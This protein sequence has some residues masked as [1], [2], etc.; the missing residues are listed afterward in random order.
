MCMQNKYVYET[1]SEIEKKEYRSAT[2]R[3]F[4][5]LQAEIRNKKYN[6]N[7]SGR[8][9]FC[10]VLDLDTRHYVT[11]HFTLRDGDEAA[12]RRTLKYS[13]FFDI[14]NK[15]IFLAFIFNTSLYVTANPKKE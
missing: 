13:Y 14:S 7:S 6:S 1:V 11:A 9:R 10:S 4:F 8:S 15:M 12:S 3:Q 5:S 2:Y